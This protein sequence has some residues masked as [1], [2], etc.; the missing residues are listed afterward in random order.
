M[1]R[2]GS[3]SLRATQLGSRLIRENTNQ[4]YSMCAD[5][6]NT[7]NAEVR[8][9]SIERQTNAATATE[10]SLVIWR[11]RQITCQV[12]TILRCQDVSAMYLTDLK[13]IRR[14]DP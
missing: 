13:R 7:R 1:A 4:W 11:S 3:Q 5:L 6:V 9:N 10:D 8:R 14:L 12:S 2:S